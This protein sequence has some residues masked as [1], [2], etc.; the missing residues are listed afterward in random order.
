MEKAV[1]I[2]GTERIKGFNH[3]ISHGLAHAVNFM[4]G[5]DE[6]ATI[7]IS[8]FDCFLMPIETYLSAY[9]KNSI[10]LKIYSDKDYKG[11]L[12]WFF[13]LPTA[14]TLGALMRKLPEKILQEKIKGLNFENEDADSFGEV[15]NQLCGILDRAF[16][17]LS[18]KNMHLT[19]DFKKPVFRDQ[20]IETSL[21]KNKEEY[22]VLL[23]TMTFPKHG[24]QK[25]TLLLPRSLYEVM[26]NLELQ[27]DKITPKT[28]ILY[29]P[30]EFYT[31]AL[32]LATN[33]RYKK[34][35]A[36]EKPEDVFT[37]LEGEGIVGAA[38]HLKQI[39][40]PLEHQDSIFLKRIASNKKLKK[41][42]FLF[43]WEN[44][45]PEG[46]ATLKAMGIDGAQEEP[47]DKA[48]P[49]WFDNLTK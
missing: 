33:N 24:A 7:K 18:S 31:E 5:S 13:E 37:S 8:D 22:V 9:K 45:T 44:Q 15:G 36:A 35:I 23:A 26:L 30:D 42:P 40:F 21:F 32:R 41:L 46:Y 1:R 2:I 17:T 43:T 28:V 16:R 47:F 29:H 4:L 27:L 34:V 6:G 39:K 38:I 11:E 10:L 3:R 14:I 20:A 25:T 48:F 12:Y 19:L 49:T